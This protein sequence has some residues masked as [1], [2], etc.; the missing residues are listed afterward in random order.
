MSKWMLA[1]VIACSV[2][3]LS[4]EKSTKPSSADD[5]AILA[6]ALTQ[7]FNDG[8]YTVVRPDTSLGVSVHDPADLGQMKKYLA[9][10]LKVPG[11][12]MPRLLD[13]FAAKN[14]KAVRLTLK[15]APEKGYV[16]DY[17]GVYERFF[18]D[19]NGGGW[20]A[21]HAQY[22]KAHGHTGVSLPLYDKASGVVLLYKGTQVHWLAGAGYVYAYKY[23]GQTL[24]EVGRVMLWVS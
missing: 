3:V 18:K 24:T 14:A 13:A 22:P 6:L 9:E 19:E 8:G 23:D 7:K 15:S 4:C 21:W 12:D 17:E 11:V 10:Q 16:V 1:F 5:N 2:N 20:E